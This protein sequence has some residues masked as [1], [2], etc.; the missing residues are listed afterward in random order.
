MRNRWV[1][2]AVNR[3]NL[4]LEALRRHNDFSAHDFPLTLF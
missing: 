1:R 2:L 3:D 4:S